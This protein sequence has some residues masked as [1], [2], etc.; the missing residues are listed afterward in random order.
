MDERM[1][2]ARG[3]RRLGAG[4]WAVVGLAVS[5]ALPWLGRWFWWAELSAHFV[6][7][8][9]VAAF[10]AALVLAGRNRPVLAAAAL[11]VFIVQVVRL[12]PLWTPPD[13][14]PLL[15]AEQLTITQV[16]V[17]FKHRDPRQ[18]IEWVLEQDPDVAVLI[19]VTRAWTE[20]MAPLRARYPKAAV[21]ISPD[22]SGIAVF[23]KDPASVLRL[24]SLVDRWCPA[25]VLDL[26][27]PS[28]PSP[29][30]MLATHLRSPVTPGDARVRNRQWAALARRIASEPAL[31]KVVVGDLNVSRWSP[32][33]SDLAT[34]GGVRD[35]QEG[36]GFAASWPSALGRWLGIPIDQT[37]V[38]SGIRVVQRTVGP[39]LGSDHL[40]V[41]T[42]IEF[43]RGMGVGAD[44]RDFAA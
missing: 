20:P 3:G 12:A 9:A 25:I 19:E 39:N 24:E 17:N 34:A 44:D 18:V 40:P 43:S 6:A 10:V 38:S 31:N 11:V 37:L 15:D 2:R 5:V 23:T 16:N 36:F 21:G 32:W 22:G 28:G 8:Y 30:A 27:R 7:Q 26:P 33:F 14:R 13:P 1:L 35:G 41:T 42:T 29:L 4:G